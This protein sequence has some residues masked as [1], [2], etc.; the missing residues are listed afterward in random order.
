LKQR[1]TVR[2]ENFGFLSAFTIIDF[3]AMED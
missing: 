3:F 1:R 2:E